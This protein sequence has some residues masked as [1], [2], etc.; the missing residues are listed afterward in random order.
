MHDE[1][2]GGDG[3]SP[4]AEHLPDRRGCCRRVL[5]SS[6]CLAVLL[7]LLIG[8]LALLSVPAEPQP[9]LEGQQH[10]PPA[11]AAG[12]GAPHAAVGVLPKPQK[13]WSALVLGGS[14]A[15][16]RV[17]VAK[18]ASKSVCTQRAETQRLRLELSVSQAAER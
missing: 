16:G 9:Q 12:A 15:T 18:L 7:L 11:A 8:F 17:L 6:P 3:S 14:G 2:R 10:A 5:T 1:K 13:P 4:P